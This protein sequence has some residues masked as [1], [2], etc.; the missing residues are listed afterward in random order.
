ME[1]TPALP[2]E[3]ECAIFA[4]AAL[5]LSATEI[6]VLFLVARRVKE[7]VEPFLVYRTV[8]LPP[9]SPDLEDDGFP[10]IPSDIFLNALHTKPPSFFGSVVRHLFIPRYA[11]M[12]SIPPILAVCRGITALFV[13]CDLRP[14]HELL[15]SFNS[16]E[17]LSIRLDELFSGDQPV[18]VSSPMFAQI[19]HLEVLDTSPSQL[20]VNS[21]CEAVGRIPQ[22][23]HLAFNSVEFCLSLPR[24]IRRSLRCVVLRHRWTD[25]RTPHMGGG[26]LGRDARFVCVAG[27]ADY[28]TDWLRGVN[29]GDDYWAR[30]DALVTAKAAG[31][32]KREC[33]ISVN[34]G[35]NLTSVQEGSSVFRAQGNGASID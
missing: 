20:F 21:V 12:S 1:V 19:T 22:L 28:E 23:T 34:N 16:L 29:G 17:R 8:L 25:L 35:C 31:Q 18:D 30:A 5:G 27:S 11:D 32:V 10:R 26:A 15:A 33:I 9:N 24:Y 6:P 3:L 4:Y 14:H 2:P 7:W 13:G